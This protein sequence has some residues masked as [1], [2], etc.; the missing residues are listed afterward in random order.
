MKVNEI[1]VKDKLTTK[2]LRASTSEDLREQV[3][4]LYARPTESTVRLVEDMILAIEEDKPTIGY[5]LALDLEI[6]VPKKR[7]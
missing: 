6:T 2:I 1:R 4:G 3:I 5:E 7:R